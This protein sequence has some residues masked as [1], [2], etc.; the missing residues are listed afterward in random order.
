MKTKWSVEGHG[1]LT[2]PDEEL[3][4]L[5]VGEKTKIIDDYVYEEFLKQVFPYWEIVGD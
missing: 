4:S 3:K 5:S 2:I 1:T